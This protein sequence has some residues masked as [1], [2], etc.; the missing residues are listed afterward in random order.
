MKASIN[1]SEDTHNWSIKNIHFTNQELTNEIKIVDY[2]EIPEK[3]QL[4]LSL[5]SKLFVGNQLKVIMQNNKIIISIT[6]QVHSGN[7][8]DFY[9]SDWQNYY[10]QSYLR[11]RN[12]CLLLPGDNFFLLRYFLIPDEFLLKIILGMFPEN[13]F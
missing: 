6:E 10:P 12:V 3:G 4:I 5:Y 1:K 7:S 2:L 11:M 13:F 9:I 8:N